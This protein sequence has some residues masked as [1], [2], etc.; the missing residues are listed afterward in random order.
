MVLL[1]SNRVVIISGQTL[2]DRRHSKDQMFGLSNYDFLVRLL[3]GWMEREGFK[4]IFLMES[5]IK[6]AV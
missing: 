3:Y 5:S 2:H 1:W 4:N 6:K